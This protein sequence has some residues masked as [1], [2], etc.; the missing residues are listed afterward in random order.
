LKVFKFGGASVRSANAVINVSCIVEM[1]AKD[2]LIIIV[3][4]MG[5]TT[6]LLETIY[7]KQFSSSDF[8]PEFDEL[9]KFH[10]ELT[11]DLLNDQQMVDAVIDPLLAGL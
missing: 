5:K 9:T 6:N 2:R 4:A 1:H 7:P 11:F 3:S 8:E 10:K